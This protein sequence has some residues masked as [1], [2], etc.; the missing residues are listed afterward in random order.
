MFCNPILTFILIKYYTDIDERLFLVRLL[1]LLQH[2]PKRNLLAVERM[3]QL[4]EN[5]FDISMLIS[6][7]I[8]TKC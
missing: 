6:I 4:L 7:K 1:L 2:A 8:S 5:H 3:R